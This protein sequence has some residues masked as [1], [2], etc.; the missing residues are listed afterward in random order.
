MFKVPVRAWVYTSSAGPSINAAQAE[1]YINAVNEFY[2]QNGVSVQLYLKCSASFIANDTYFN[3]PSEQM[4]QDNYDSNALNVHFVNSGSTNKGRFPWKA[5]RYSCWF[6]T[7][8]GF[9][10]NRVATLSHE[11]GHCLGLL[12][13][14]E[15]ARESLKPTNG[16]AGDCYQESVVDPGL[17]GSAASVPLVNLNVLLTVIIY[18]IPKQ[19]PASPKTMLP[20]AC[21]KITGELPIGARLGLPM[22][23]TL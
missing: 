10:Q 22:F 18:G 14:F 2:R 7:F 17:K 20:G 6:T 9:N 8:G 11:I 4:W 5:R 16:S 13:T 1:Q 19:I 15:S 3:N 12:H 21:I 23:A